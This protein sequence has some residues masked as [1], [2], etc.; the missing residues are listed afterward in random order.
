MFFFE[1]FDKGKTK[2]G[3]KEKSRSRSAS[4][5]L[6][7]RPKMER[8]HMLSF[9][10]YDVRANNRVRDERLHRELHRLYLWNGESE[11]ECPGHFD[12]VADVVREMS[13]R[14]GV[15]SAT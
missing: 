15:I 1:L 4:E 8:G 9:R 6:P 13:G 5:E 11:S 2:D 7:P 12:T 10:K 3:G 14:S